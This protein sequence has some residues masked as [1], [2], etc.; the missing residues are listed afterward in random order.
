MDYAANLRDLWLILA[1]GSP[2]VRGG[3]DL[4][5]PDPRRRQAEAATDRSAGL[6]KHT[7]SA[8]MACLLLRE[9]KVNGTR[10]WCATEERCAAAG[11]GR[12]L[13]LSDS[14]SAMSRSR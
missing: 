9:K 12:P 5:V 3:E 10:A 14:R 2:S 8:V 6:A 1:S 11:G 13:G 7:M 4:A